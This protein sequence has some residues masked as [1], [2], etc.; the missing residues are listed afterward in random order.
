MPEAVPS[1]PAHPG[2]GNHTEL[3]LSTNR[4]D[5]KEFPACEVIRNVALQSGKQ[6]AAPLGKLTLLETVSL[7]AMARKDSNMN[8]SLNEPAT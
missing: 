8:N 2:L 7:L 4:T 3:R 6:K 5:T 1:I